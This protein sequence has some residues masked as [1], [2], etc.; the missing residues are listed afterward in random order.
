MHHCAQCLVL[1]FDQPYHASHQQSQ[2]C[3]STATPAGAA[4]VE[5]MHPV[6]IG[7]ARFKMDA[8]CSSTAHTLASARLQYTPVFG[9]HLGM[10][11]M[12]TNPTI[13]S[14]LAL[15]AHHS[16]S[17]LPTACN[18]S[19]TCGCTAGL[20]LFLFVAFPEWHIDRTHLVDRTRWYGD[21]ISYLAEWTGIIHSQ[22]T[23][24]PACVDRTAARL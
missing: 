15:F 14:S 20:H 2:T 6:W 10:K 24:F 9:Q 16:M 18:T 21:T 12:F 8:T 3:H 19:A 7:L 13:A 11:A 5:G 23:T 17:L 1:P 22:A 4:C